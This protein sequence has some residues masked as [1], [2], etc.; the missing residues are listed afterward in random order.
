[1]DIRGPRCSRSLSV[2]IFLWAFRYIHATK[3]SSATSSASDVVSR[4]FFSPSQASASLGSLHTQI[5]D[6]E[7]VLQSQLQ[8]SLTHSSA[9]D[10]Q[11]IPSITHI[12]ARMS[13]LVIWLWNRF[14]GPIKPDRTMNQRVEILL[15]HFSLPSS[16]LSDSE[17]AFKRFLA[18]LDQRISQFMQEG[19]IV[20]QPRET[21]IWFTSALYEAH[22]IVQQDRSGRQVILMPPSFPSDMKL[23]T[24]DSRHSA[25]IPDSHSG[26]NSMLSGGTLQGMDVLSLHQTPSFGPLLD[27]ENGRQHLE[28]FGDGTSH[29]T[30][31]S[32]LDQIPSLVP[33]LNLGGGS[34]NCHGYNGKACVFTLVFISALFWES[35]PHV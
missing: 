16:D 10:L 20:T 14:K 26:R 1:M 29:G 32:Y 2:D 25:A 27:L 22:K 15:N 13:D 6:D 9:S 21:E 4:Q 3:M 35:R 17:S 31:V 24:G 5:D 7:L 34:Q 12:P 28:E 8:P 11:T 30:D 33:L 18:E 23:E 19:I